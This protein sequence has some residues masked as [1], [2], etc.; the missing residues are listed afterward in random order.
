[1]VDFDSTGQRIETAW[2][3]IPESE[4]P[5]IRANLTDRF[6]SAAGYEKARQA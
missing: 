4:L 3:D 6:M 2:S 1:M 5:A